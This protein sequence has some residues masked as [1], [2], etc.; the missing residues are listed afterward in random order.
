MDVSIITILE[1]G[2]PIQIF[3]TFL[4]FLRLSRE[5]VFYSNS[6]MFKYLLF[7]FFVP[8]LGY[9]LTLLKH[10]I[11]ESQSNETTKQ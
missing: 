1:F 3:L 10:T 7:C 4:M 5:S 8:I 6:R 9:V 11:N 2:V